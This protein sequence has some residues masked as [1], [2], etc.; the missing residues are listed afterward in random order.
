MRLDSSGGRRLTYA[1]LAAREHAIEA[2]R[3]V[4]RKE[5]AAATRDAMK[6]LD[7][8]PTLRL[9]LGE[10]AGCFGDS[11]IED[12]II[13]WPSN[14]YLMQRTGLSERSIRYGIRGLVDAQLV[15][16]RD[17][18]NG[19]RFA[20]KRGGVVIDA[21]GFDL[22]PVFARR[23]EW[24]ELIERK[25]L[26]RDIQR[27]LF[28]DITVA[29]R[30]TEEAIAAIASNYP[31]AAHSELGERLVALVRST[32]RRS[33]TVSRELLEGLLEDYRAMRVE[34]ETAFYKAGS[35]GKDCRLKETNTEK[36][37]IKDCNSDIQMDVGEI[38]RPKHPLPSI[39]LISE[40]C[41][42]L[43]EYG[44]NA[45]TEEDV[46]VAGSY[47]RGSIG[48]SPDAWNEA[49][50]L[51][52]PFKA[53]VMV[54]ITLQLHEDDVSSGQHRIKNPGGYFRAMVRLHAAGRFDITAELMTLRRRRMT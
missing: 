6:A 44:Q 33:G 42:S 14:E 7:L 40:A 2:E 52:G 32:P 48:A 43:V 11:L 8:R 5:L 39:D 27:A 35:G 25:N 37:F 51:F 30:A 24:V 15:I 23:G 41:P 18:P 53:A 36:S 13:V 10:L 22:T 28:D 1:A 3:G 4:S 26:A 34:A 31:E 47:L 21:Y 46:I 20:R 29:R 12:R 16:T 38:P 50:K 54:L 45:R 19:K 9:V 49:L 17:S